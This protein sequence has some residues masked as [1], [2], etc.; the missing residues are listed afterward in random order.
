MVAIE[1]A[2]HTAAAKAI[3]DREALE[4]QGAVPRD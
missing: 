2:R 3:A 1:R 4:K